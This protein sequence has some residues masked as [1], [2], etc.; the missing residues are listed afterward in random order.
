MKKNDKIQ[1]TITDMGVNGEGIGKKDGYTFFVKNA[2]IGDTVSAVITKMK[3][4][5]GYAKTLQVLTPSA[6]RVDPPCP[7][8]SR[9]GGCQIMEL[10][11]KAQ[12]KYKEQKVKNNLERIGGLDM[13]S[14]EFLP[15]IGMDKDVPLHYRNKM[16]YPFGRTA[17]GHVVTGFYAGRTHYLIETKNCPVALQGDE[18]IRQAVC[19]FA[20]QN[21]LSVYDE[22]KGTG[23][24]RHL[25]I[26]R[27]SATGQVMVCLVING[28]ELGTLDLERSFVAALKAADPAIRSIC[29]NINKEKTNVILGKTLRCLSGEL[30]IEEKITC[31]KEPLRFQISPLSFFQVN[32][33]QTERLYGTALSFAALKGDET[34]WDLY[35]GTGTISLFLSKSAKKVIGVEVIPAAIEDA[36]ENAWLNGIDNAQFLCGKAEELFPEAVL[37]E[38]LQADVVVLDPPRKGCDARLLDTIRKVGPEKIVYVS[39][40]S[41]TLARDLKILTGGADGDNTDSL[42]LQ[43]Y[44]V[45]KVQPV[46]MFPHTVHVESVVL[47][48]KTEN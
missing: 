28:D 15:I 4:G 43:N 46:D 16:Q 7:E 42:R 48:I 2:V 30:Y 32:T 10:S 41:A 6:D 9:C 21:A 19:T 38:N 23:L 26:R 12:L 29:L 11:Y 39:C 3:K 33:A 27:G 22:E 31:G 44:T 35:C 8:A 24:L 5:Y 13:T 17:D 20:E 45:K 25:L 36:N 14:I 37:Q 18:K 1:L 34:V 47:M 40:D